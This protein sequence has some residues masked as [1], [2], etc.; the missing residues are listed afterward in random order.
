MGYTIKQLSCSKCNKKLQ[1]GDFAYDQSVCLD[2]FITEIESIQDNIDMY[3]P[4]W[5]S[6]KREEHKDILEHV[7]SFYRMC[8]N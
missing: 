6:G 1:W 5:L 7:L 2:C 8:E 3:Y 4:S